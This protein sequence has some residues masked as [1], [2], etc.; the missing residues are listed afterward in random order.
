MRHA[1]TAAALAPL[2][3]AA[4]SVDRYDVKG[5]V[6]VGTAGSVERISAGRLESPAWRAIPHAA[7]RVIMDADDTLSRRDLGILRCDAQGFF[8]LRDLNAPGVE[9]V[10]YRLRIDGYAPGF[11]PLHADAALPSPGGALILRMAEDPAS[12]GIPPNLAPER[13]APSGDP[14]K[15]TLKE[16]A[17]YLK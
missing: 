11:A 2:L 10:P 14:L 7:V 8:T 17:P 9:L 5:R 4:C 16:G 12:P 3:L 15:E 6:V 13:P 1:L